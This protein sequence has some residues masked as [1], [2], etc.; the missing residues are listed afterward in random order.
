MLIEVKLLT[1]TAQRVTLCETE[2]KVIYERRFHAENIWYLL[3]EELILL[4]DEMYKIF[5]F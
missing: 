3:T 5:F 4:S 1:G 2:Y